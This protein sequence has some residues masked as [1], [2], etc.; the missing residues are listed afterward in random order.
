MMSRKLL[1]LAIIY[2]FIFGGLVG[3]K[4]EILLLA[5]PFV[6][7]LAV[8]LFDSPAEPE[9]Q[10]DRVIEPERALPGM[11]VEIR[12]TIKN[13][14]LRNCIVTLQDRAHERLEVISGDSRLLASLAPGQ[15]TELEYIVKGGR[16]IYLFDH[17]K[18]TNLGKDGLFELEKSISTPGQ[19]FVLPHI[20]QLKHVSI[21]IRQTKVYS[22]NIPSR[23][24]GFG[25]DF[26]G[27]R[28]YQPGDSLRYINWRISA[29][30]PDSLFSNEF[31]RERVMDTWLILDGRQRSNLRSGDSELFEHI[32]L[33]G[34]GLAQAL[35]K[36]GNRVG[37]LV[38]GGY[39]R[40]TFPGYGKIQRERILR[41]LAQATPGDLFI[42]SD[43]ENLPTR[44]FPI[45]SQLVFISP[46]HAEDISI[47]L[48]LRARGY[49]ILIIS[50]DPVLFEKGRLTLEDGGNSGLRIASVE[51]Q[52]Y[53]R[54]LQNAGIRVINWDVSIPFER[55]VQTPLRIANRTSLPVRQIR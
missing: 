24:S 44:A 50:P 10:I 28:E 49:A 41:T 15:T 33:S 16:G 17:L 21:R 34:A 12:V 1:I 45:S 42:F 30:Y 11:A 3:L 31:E 23:V 46:L 53:L 26:Y 6:I 19:M 25:T 47:L 32:V 55:A 48:K 52:L 14:G 39:L 13:S 18:V 7:Y 37:L 2:G 4:G 54:K 36:E 29:R 43:F 35:I 8:G 51:R 5:L 22:G 20:P 38:Y 9:L 27:V 40:W